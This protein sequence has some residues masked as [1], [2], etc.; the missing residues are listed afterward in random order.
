MAKLDLLTTFYDF[1]SKKK[2]VLPIPVT[3]ILKQKM[4]GKHGLMTHGTA[5]SLNNVLQYM[6]FV[7][8]SVI[9]AYH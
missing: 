5:S 4:T 6:R 8:S 3:G 7:S 1:H 9:I 2:T